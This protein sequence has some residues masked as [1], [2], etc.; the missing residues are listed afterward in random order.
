MTQRSLFALLTAMVLVGQLATSLYI[1][2]LPAIAA[3][4][5]ADPGW[6]KAT[7]TVYLATF[8]VAQLVLGPLSDRIGRR[9]VMIH[10]LALYV[11]ASAACAM[12]PTIEW[13]LAGRVVQAIGGCACM[14]I[15][16]AIVRDRYDQVDAQR[17]MATM[18]M[19]MAISPALGPMIGGQLQLHFGW[20]SNFVALALVGA[21]IWV[22]VQRGMGE[23][24]ARLDP[25]ATDPRRLLRNTVALISHRGFM[26]NMIVIGCCFAG[27]FGFV[28]ALPFVM[29][30]VFSIPPH[31]VAVLFIFTVAGFFCGSTLARVFARRAAS[32]TLV[33]AGAL[34][35]LAGGV[36]ALGL[37]IAGIRS[38]AAILAP[39]VLFMA[40]FGLMVPSAMAAGMQPFPHI[41]G[42]A[43]A[44]LGCSQMAM[45]ALGTIV[46]AVFYDG[47]EWVV[48]LLILGCGVGATLASR[49]MLR[50]PA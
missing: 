31:V 22:W 18:G 29:L 6:V 21:V 1:P 45:A 15:S 42:T 10:G 3:A 9:P 46:V 12:A 26:G 40:G 47:T 41:A 7:M 37:E 17:V 50:R 43:S 23:S 35:A 33:E 48:V 4:L 36:L 8:G 27:L 19:V 14:A 25:T 30:D 13:L 11:A 38:V 5:A 44:L 20:R 39:L 16:R 32:E 49:L 24:N 2:A 28:T 34:L